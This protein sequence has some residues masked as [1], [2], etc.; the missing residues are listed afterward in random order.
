MER[1]LNPK[2][3][4]DLGPKM[5]TDFGAPFSVQRRAFFDRGRTTQKRAPKNEYRNR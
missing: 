3:E 1:D 4:R 5:V 2:M